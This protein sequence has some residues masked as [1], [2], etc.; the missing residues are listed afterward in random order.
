M[1]PKNKFQ[2]QVFEASR[3]LSKITDAQV[4]WAQKNC[5]EHI[6]RRSAKGVITCTVCGHAWQGH[7]HL[8]ETLTDC[9]C[10]ECG[11]KLK[12]DTTRKSK[13]NDCQYMCIATT[14]E[15]FQV[16]RFVWVEC[17]MRAGEKARY[18]HSEVVQRWIAPDGRHATVARMRPMMCFSDGW[19]WTSKLEIRPEKPNLYNIHPTEIYPRSKYTPELTQRGYT[20]TYGRLSPFDLMKALL[21]QSKMETLLKAGQT[22]LLE[23]FVF[24][25]RSVDAYWPSIRIAIRN[26]YRIEDAGAWVDYLDL[27]RHFGKDTRNAHYVCPADLHGEHDR[28]VAKKQAQREREETERKRKRALEDEQRFKELKARFFGIEFTDGTISVR[29]LESVEEIMREGDALHHCVFANNYHTRPDSL[30]L[31]ARIGGERLETIEISLSRL[32]VVQCRGLLNN[33]TPYHKQIVDL[34]KRNIPLIQQRLAA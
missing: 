19:N 18:F 11:T 6:G 9:H 21:S 32:A 30:I 26:G 23:Y 5:I 20:G 10:P 3:R 29:V 33:P 17:H 25:S 14:C 34:V 22:A 15:G 28:Y 12:V 7:S 4:R 1:K 24:T 31:S 27:L 2:Q 8:I 13:F 16:L